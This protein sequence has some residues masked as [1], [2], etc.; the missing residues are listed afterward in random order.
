M[1]T[2]SVDREA[3]LSIAPCL[4]KILGT[5]D[6]ND[7]MMAP[8]EQV[9]MVYLLEKIRPKVAI[10]IGTRFG[11]SLQVLANYSEKVYS[12]DIDSEVSQRLEGKYDNVTFLTGDAAELLPELL[13]QLTRENAEVEFVL[14]DGD[15]SAEG[16][17]KDIDNVLQYQP[18]VPL[19]VV[20]HDSFN[21]V[22]REGL[23]NAHWSDCPYVH[24]VELDFIPGT[25][26]TDENF[27]NELWV[28]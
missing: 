9:G 27:P 18:R 23:L 16:V 20:M 14:V 26:S 25:M 5:T 8:A 11:G 22:C 13:D 12:I 17:Q 10:E 28:Y 19:Y 6:F 24:T 1:T 3:R 21:P 15:H 2:H 4:E 7:W